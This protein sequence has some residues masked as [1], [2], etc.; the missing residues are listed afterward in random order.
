MAVRYAK[1]PMAVLCTIYV[2][3]NLEARGRPFKSLSISLG[4]KLAEKN[5]CAPGKAVH[6]E[7]CGDFNSESLQAGQGGFGDNVLISVKPFAY[8]RAGPGQPTYTLIASN[9][10]LVQEKRGAKHGT[11]AILK[12]KYFQFR[13]SF[14]IG[15]LLP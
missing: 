15:Q 14:S 8:C 1:V 10:G 9:A 11:S 6:V 12:K 13:R 5:F 3:T 2:Q 7:V 4:G